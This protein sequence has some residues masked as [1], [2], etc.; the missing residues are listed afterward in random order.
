MT[1]LVVEAVVG[2]CVDQL[3]GNQARGFGVIEVNREERKGSQGT[4]ERME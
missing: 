1:V 2:C 3:L 4:G